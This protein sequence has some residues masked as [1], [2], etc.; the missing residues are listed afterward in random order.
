MERCG[1]GVIEDGVEHRCMLKIRHGTSCSASR[2]MARK[3]SY[4]L[5]EYGTHCRIEKETP[6]LKVSIVVAVTVLKSTAPALLA[7]CAEA[8]V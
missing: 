4:V 1:A 8:K 5:R 7:R 2:I 6:G 3:G